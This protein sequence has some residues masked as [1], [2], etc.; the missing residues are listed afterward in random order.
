VDVI[1]RRMLSPTDI[2]T[3]TDMIY[4]KMCKKGISKKDAEYLVN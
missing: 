2:K 3:Y 1:E 4:S